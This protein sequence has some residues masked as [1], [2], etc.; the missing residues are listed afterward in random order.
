MKRSSVSWVAALFCAAIFPT[1]AHAAAPPN[2]SYKRTCAVQTFT[3][4]VLTAACQPD[5]SPNFRT[6][7]ID[8]LAC[9]QDP[10][11]FNRDGGLQCYTRQ[12]WGSGRA[13]PRGSYIDSCKDVIVSGD[14]RTVTAQCKN[15][16]GKYQRTEITT[17]SCRLGNGLD[18]QNGR[19]ACH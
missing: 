1:I 13:V 16:N 7:Q 4:S 9:R 8:I 19:L 10:D 5:D 17:G 18:N 3:G 12:G 11:V 14:Q 2:G 6:T 15:N